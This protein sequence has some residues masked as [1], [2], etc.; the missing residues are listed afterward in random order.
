M[1]KVYQA[2]AG[3][4]IAVGNC[5]NSQNTEW[6]S[7]HEDA[8]AEIIKQSA[9]SGSG[10]DAGTKFDIGDNLK[11]N[12]QK[13]VFQTAYHH[14]NE[15][16]GYDGWTEHTITVTP[17]L[18]NGFNLKISGRDRDSIKEYLHEVYSEWLDSKIED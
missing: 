11:F 17:S 2:L 7:K 16:G 3:K 1:K 14:M 10:I 8:I 4:I 18:W 12:G 5:I 9:P 15:G 13:L 6:Q